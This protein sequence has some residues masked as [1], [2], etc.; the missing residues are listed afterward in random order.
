MRV[1]TNIR[2]RRDIES[3]FAY[4][5][6]PRRMPAWNS[7]VTDVRPEDGDT[8]GRRYVMTR[9]LPTGTATNGLLVTAVDA[10]VRFAIETTS[11]PTPFR[12][13]YRFTAADGATTVALDARADLTS[14]GVLAPLARRGLARGIE[15][16][17]QTL[18][19]ILE[20][21]GAALV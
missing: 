15:A 10:P 13:E 21:N 4:V 5:T 14:L 2:I 20:R 7:A 1:E 17:L 6:D 3:V 12:Y 18:R 11:G 9:R 16:N 8:A 19:R